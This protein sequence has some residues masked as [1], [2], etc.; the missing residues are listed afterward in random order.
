MTISHLNGE[1]VKVSQKC[2]NLIFL[3][4]LM[5]CHLPV[6]VVFDHLSNRPQGTS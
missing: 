3:L 6:S 2:F 1:L 5:M 4:F